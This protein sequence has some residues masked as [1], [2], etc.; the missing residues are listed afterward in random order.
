MKLKN[1]IMSWVLSPGAYA[2]WHSM[3]SPDEWVWHAY[4]DPLFE[5]K[6]TQLCV[7]MDLWWKMPVPCYLFPPLWIVV[8]LVWA[9]WPNAGFYVVDHDAAIGP[10]D[11]Q[12]IAG[13][14]MRLRKRLLYLERTKNKRAANLA[15][16][17]RLTVNE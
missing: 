12:L 7:R 17:K 4:K 9:F 1:R 11:A 3:G 13:R 6:T 15:V 5:H 14:M 2:L 16:F 8:V 10:I